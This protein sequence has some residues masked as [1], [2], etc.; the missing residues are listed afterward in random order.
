ME[1]TLTLIILTILAGLVKGLVGFGLSLILISVL[2]N[3]GLSPTELLPILVPI[4]VILDLILYYQNRNHITINYNENFTLHSTTLMTLFIGILLGTFT[5]TIFDAEYLK[6]LFAFIVLILL[7]FLIEKVDLHQMRIPSKKQNAFF[8]TI[9]GFL[10]GLF[11]MNA[12]PASLYLIYH[13]YPKEK[14]M[15]SLVTFLLFSDIILISVYLFK[16][17]FTISG[18]IISL[19]LIVIVI[20]GFLIGSYFRNKLSSSHF[21]SIVIL[22]LAISSL[23]IIFNF[24][25]LV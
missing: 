11:T 3:I 25:F 16:N 7:L 24:F 9:S 18:L 1:L 10:T 2:L 22:I 17:L 21:K 23:K 14:Y 12:I 4:F 6:L 15:A 20:L 8:G 5:L 13:Q 19:E